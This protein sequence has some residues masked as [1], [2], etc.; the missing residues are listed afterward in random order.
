[1]NVYGK[2]AFLACGLAAVVASGTLL[3]LGDMRGAL[4][5]LFALQLLLNA[6]VARKVG[7]ITLEMAPRQE[8]FSTTI[9]KV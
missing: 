7:R 9:L 2:R 1:M 3:Y 6:A 8:A 5:A 4:A